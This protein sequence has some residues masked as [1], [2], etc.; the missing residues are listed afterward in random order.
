MKWIVFTNKLNNKE[1]LKLSIEGLM[2]NEIEIT[3]SF[4]AY[5]NNI[6]ITDIKITIT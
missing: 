4:L 5:E 2:R 1:L 3:K 6:N